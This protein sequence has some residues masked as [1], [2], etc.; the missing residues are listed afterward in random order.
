MYHDIK[1]LQ[2]QM[3]ALKEQLAEAMLRIHRLEHKGRDE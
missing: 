3:A 2:E 1:Q